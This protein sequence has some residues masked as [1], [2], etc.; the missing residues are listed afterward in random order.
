MKIFPKKFL[1]GAKISTHFNTSVARSISGHEQRNINWS[2]PYKEIHNIIDITS[3]VELRK[4]IDFFEHHKGR[5]RSF[6]F[7]NPIDCTIRGL[8]C[9]SPIKLNDLGVKW[10][11]VDSI[12]IY[13]DVEF[14]QYEYDATSNTIIF[15]GEADTNLNVNYCYIGRFDMDSLDVEFL[16]NSIARI[17]FKIIELR[18]NEEH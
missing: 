3:A 6:L 11:V 5:G 7:E 15:A 8:R 4:F 17:E 14:L 18:E 1:I 13:N 12:E 16:P 9:A 10:P 2:R